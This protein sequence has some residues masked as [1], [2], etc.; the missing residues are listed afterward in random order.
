M[1]KLLTSR[2]S[3]HSEDPEPTLFRTKTLWDTV[4]NCSLY[5]SGLDATEVVLERTVLR[6]VLHVATVG[7][8][9]ASG[10]FG[11]VVF[12]GELGEAPLL[13]DNNLLATSE[14]VLAAAEGLNDVGLVV[15]FCPDGEKDLTD[16]DTS[17]GTSGLTERTTHTSLQTIGTSAR[18]HL[19]DAD[20]VEGVDADTQMER[21]LSAGLGHVLVGANTGGF[22]S[23]GSNLLLLIGDKVHTEGELVDGSLLT[24]KVENPNLRVRDATAE[25]GF[26]VRLVL[27]PAVAASR[28]ATHFY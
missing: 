24:S 10:T 6:K 4:K 3:K 8:E 12:P 20:H 9:A 26:G 17:D 22:Q 14:L 13:G 15:L 11:D 23:F 28:T 25:T 18:Q 16:A 1:T 19:V 21:V 5:L 7:L 27:T 2:S